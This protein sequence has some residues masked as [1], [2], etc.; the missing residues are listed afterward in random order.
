M[1]GDNAEYGAYQFTLK[2]WRIK[3][4]V[5]KITPIKIGQ[6]VTLYKRV[7]KQPIQPYEA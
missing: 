5:A 2:E 3:F 7:D 1:E 4:R 6:F